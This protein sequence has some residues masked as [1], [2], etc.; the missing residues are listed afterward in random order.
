MDRGTSF[1]TIYIR[2]VERRNGRLENIEFSTSPTVPA[3]ERVDAS[4]A[5]SDV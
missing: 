5:S 4:I 2:R 3:T 1:Q